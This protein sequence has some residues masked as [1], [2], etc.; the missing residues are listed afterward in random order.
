VETVATIRPEY[1]KYIQLYGLPEGGVFDTEK[2]ADIITIMEAEN[3][4]Q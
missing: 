3:N 2:L 4:P 1:I